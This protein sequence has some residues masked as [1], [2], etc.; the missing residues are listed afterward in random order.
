MLYEVITNAGHSAA[1]DKNIATEAGQPLDTEGKIYLILFFE[2][3]LLG[4]GEDGIEEVLR[5]IRLQGRPL[6]G[7]HLPMD[8]NRNNFV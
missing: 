7:G 5:I 8:T 3:T 4:I 2:L 1:L 6:K